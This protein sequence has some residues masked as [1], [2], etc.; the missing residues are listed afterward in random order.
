MYDDTIENLLKGVADG[1][2]SVK[3]ARTALEGVE[4]TEEQMDAAIDHGVHNVAESGTI[5]SASLG[6]S[7][8]YAIGPFHSFTDW[9]M[10]GINRTWHSILPWS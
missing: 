4:L 7:F 8:G 9:P 2:I 1:S 10:I 6:E 5:V 3:D